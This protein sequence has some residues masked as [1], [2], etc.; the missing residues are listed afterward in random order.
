M[1]LPKEYLE[2]LKD[3]KVKTVYTTHDYYGLCPKML[4][5]DPLDKLKSS[6]C[7]YDCMLC[8]VGPSLN[9]IHL[10]QSHFYQTFKELKV[11]KYLR[12]KQRKRITEDLNTYHFNKEQVGKRYH[13]R[14]YYLQMFKLIDYYHFNSSVSESVYKKYLP[15]I[16]GK[17]LPIVEKGL[18]RSSIKKEAIDPVTIGF[19]GGVSTKK[20]FNQIKQVTNSLVQKGLSFKL[21]CAGSESDDIFLKN[22]M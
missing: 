7:S 19:L 11:V 2:V 18:Q 21:L 22:Q 14:K 13:L 3:E 4:T 16:K 6:E 10:M 20:G 15:N 9:K 17:V 8:S 5:N 1:G 12:E